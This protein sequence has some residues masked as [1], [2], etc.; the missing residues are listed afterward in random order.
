MCDYPADVT[1]C[2]LY[3]D[4]QASDCVLVMERVVKDMTCDGDNQRMK[5][6][7]ALCSGVFS[8][9]PDVASSETG[10]AS[11]AGT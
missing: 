5:N 2:T 10:G 8:G 9:C 3:D 4:D 6:L 1:G 11:D 7:N